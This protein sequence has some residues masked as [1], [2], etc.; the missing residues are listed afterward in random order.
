MTRRGGRHP[1][2]TRSARIRLRV[3]PG[4]A[5]LLV[6]VCVAPVI[7]AAV[8]S[9]AAA[10]PPRN[11]TQHGETEAQHLDAL[12]ARTADSGERWRL[13]IT[14]P[15]EGNTYVR[16][17]ADPEDAGP[18]NSRGD[19]TVQFSIVCPYSFRTFEPAHRRRVALEGSFQVNEDIHTLA[20]KEY[21]CGPETVHHLTLAAAFP[22][23][24][25][26]HHGVLRGGD[27][28]LAVWLEGTSRGQW[29]GGRA[30]AS[31][32]G[33]GGEADAD[34][35]D[36]FMSSLTRFRFVP[37]AADALS[38][39]EHPR[40]RHES[41]STRSVPTAGA[42]G[43]GVWAVQE[44]ERLGRRL[45]IAV[46]EPG[47]EPGGRRGG[48]LLHASV[49]EQYAF[50][51]E[52]VLT[53]DEHV[54]TV[55]SQPGGRASGP[56]VGHSLTDKPRRWLWSRSGDANTDAYSEIPME[57]ASGDAVGEEEPS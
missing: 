6:V 34:V 51:C 19:L 30:S 4:L 24:S 18:I 16:S 55:D 14:V 47:M 52:Y 26:R 1:H 44:E 8:S 41:S 38:C 53:V 25:R 11:R 13:V 10:S 37:C 15:A 20:R 49:Q 28:T 2:Q 56:H 27:N 12:A 42:E 57:L 29:R 46:L 22:P 9:A 50:G 23:G 48:G 31:E 5:V 33:A 35:V 21:T 54:R 45:R 32:E 7:A 39:D 3:A 36:I 17:D 43:S 40:L